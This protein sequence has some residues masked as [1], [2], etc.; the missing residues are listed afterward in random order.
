MN[1]KQIKFYQLYEK[2]CKFDYMSD[3]KVLTRFFDGVL[4]LDYGQAVEMWEYFTTVYDEAIA[5]DTRLSAFF[6]DELLEIFYKADSKKTIRLLLENGAVSSTVYQYGGLARIALDYL[7]EL[8]TS[9]KVEYADYLLKF[10]IKNQRLEFGP[11]FKNIMTQMLDN[12]TLKTG[13]PPKLNKKLEAMLMGYVEKIKT[14]EKA[15]LKQRLVEL[16]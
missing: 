15:L 7:L 2:L 5:K 16:K 4:T 3:T 14:P 6:S 9:G 10:I 13:Q 8:L 1:T 11:V 12:I